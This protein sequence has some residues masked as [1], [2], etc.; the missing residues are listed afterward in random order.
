MPRKGRDRVGEWEAAVAVAAAMPKIRARTERDARVPRR[1]CIFTV[2]SPSAI[3]HPTQSLTSGGDDSL[4]RNT[5]YRAHVTNR[6]GNLRGRGG[7]PG[8]RADALPGLDWST[9]AVARVLPRARKKA[10]KIL[11]M[12]LTSGSL[13]RQDVYSR[14]WVFV[15]L[16]DYQLRD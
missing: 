1:S 16:Q 15:D 11:S 9:A 5:R 13:S 6:R 12:K 10:E 7:A 3:L 2:A 8:K 14:S 4:T